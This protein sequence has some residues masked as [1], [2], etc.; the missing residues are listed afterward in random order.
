MTVPGSGP[1]AEFMLG[2]PGLG[3]QPEVRRSGVGALRHCPRT[4]GLVSALQY[5][6]FFERQRVKWLN[7]DKKVEQDTSLSGRGGCPQPAHKQ[8]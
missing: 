2:Y 3:L 5:L 4:L 7:N 1:E 8:V 6:Q